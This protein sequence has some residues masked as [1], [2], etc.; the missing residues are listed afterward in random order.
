M[1][2]PALH[3]TRHIQVWDMH[4]IVYHVCLT[5][6]DAGQVLHP[7]VWTMIVLGIIAKQAVRRNETINGFA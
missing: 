3:D 7:V 4:A 6:G 2:L 5:P 1:V